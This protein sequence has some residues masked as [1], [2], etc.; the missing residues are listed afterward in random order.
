VDEDAP[1]S[2]LDQDNENRRKTLALGLALCMAILIAIA[3]G[4]GVGLSKKNDDPPAPATLA[5]TPVPAPTAP[6]V[7]MPVSLPPREPTS[8]P[9]TTSDEPATEINVFASADTTIYRDGVLAGEP[10]GTEDTML[11]QS[12][13]AGNVDLPSAFSLVQFDLNGTSI[14]TSDDATVAIMC[15]EHLPN[16]ETDQVSTYATCRILASPDA[17]IEDWTVEDAGYTIPDDCAGGVVEF[18]VSSADESFC[19]DVTAAVSQSSSAIGLRGR[20]RQLQPVDSLLFMIDA[21][22]QGLEQAGDRFYTSNAENPEWRPSL[23]ITQDSTT[24][25]PTL[26]ETETMS[27]TNATLGDFLPCSICEDGSS[28]TM[29]EV[30]LP[31]PAE[32]LPDGVPPEEANCGLVDDLCSNG[33]CNEEVCA[34]L[35]D[36]AG[37]LGPLCGCD[38]EI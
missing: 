20:S 34:Q 13:E 22:Q 28:P 31:V 19:I 18:N 17:T 11:V 35:V 24:V 3:I 8:A 27:P 10:Q 7:R 15:L 16:I 32:L 1:K 2:A 9:T 36:F 25:S 12:G 30:V 5:P 4:L 23:S 6:P 21:A 37:T 14:D 33:F 26:T 29:P 38:L